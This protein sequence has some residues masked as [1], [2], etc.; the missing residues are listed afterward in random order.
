MA[1]TL[2]ENQTVDGSSA[3]FPIISAGDI[4]LYVSGDLGGGTLTI[5]ALDPGG[6]TVLVDGGTITATG[7]YLIEAGSFK[8]R[9]TLAGSTGADVNV[10]IE[11][12]NV[13]TRMSVR[14]R[15]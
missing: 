13:A 12:E 8:G 5:E 9:A 6:N 15:T 14:L 2:F 3:W 1:T 10:Y 4:N 7:L 11:V